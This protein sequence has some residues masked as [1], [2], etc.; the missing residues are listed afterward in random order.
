MY[1]TRQRLKAL[2][3]CRGGKSLRIGKQ[4]AKLIHL[5]LVE[6]NVLINV[7][8]A[9]CPVGEPLNVN[10]NILPSNMKISDTV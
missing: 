6:G 4:P 5:Q 1:I 8:L 2:P 9:S 7:P 10:Y 3:A